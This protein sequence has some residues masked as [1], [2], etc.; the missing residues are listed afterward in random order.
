MSYL[1][2][3]APAPAPVR[4]RALDMDNGLD[5]AG[6]YAHR[7]FLIRVFQR[8]SPY[9]TLTAYIL[10]RARSCRDRR[11]TIR[12]WCVSPLNT[13]ASLTVSRSAHA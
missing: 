4:A 6:A 2:H 7:V 10:T 3:A 12:P 5:S 13:R 8:A 9:L 11:R 1:P